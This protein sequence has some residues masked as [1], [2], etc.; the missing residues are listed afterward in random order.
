MGRRAHRAHESDRVPRQQLEPLDH[1]LEGGPARGEADERADGAIAHLLERAR[2][3]LQAVRLERVAQLRS[4]GRARHGNCS[5]GADFKNRTRAAIM[6]ASLRAA[7]RRAA[8]RMAPARSLASGAAPPKNMVA[9]LD[10]R[11]PSHVSRDEP[12]QEMGVRRRPQRRA[13]SRRESPA[14]L[15]SPRAASIFILLI[16]ADVR[17]QPPHRP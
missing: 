11:G 13:R 8:R 15:V 9:M 16:P 14:L 4:N 6:L 10:T 1:L 5:T 2:V 3:L 7:P 17:S 12:M